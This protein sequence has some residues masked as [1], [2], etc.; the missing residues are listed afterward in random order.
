MYFNL[1][2]Q[3]VDDRLAYDSC[4]FK[5]ENEKTFDTLKG[6]HIMIKEKT[7]KKR[8]ERNGEEL[9]KV[10]LSYWNLHTPSSYQIALDWFYKSAKKDYPAASYYIGWMYY[11]GR[12]LNIDK[13]KSFQW[14]SR[15]SRSGEKY[16]HLT[17]DM[18][19]KGN[20][21]DKHAYIND[22]VEKT[23]LKKSFMSTFWE[24]IVK[25]KKLD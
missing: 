6:E 8:K 14:Y 24:A 21:I 25:N 23:K 16:T 2:Y 12:G 5:G 15:A 3:Y 7:L 9:F 1:T 20:N 18:F 19:S 11:D 13:N 22:S 17:F 10:G 4:K